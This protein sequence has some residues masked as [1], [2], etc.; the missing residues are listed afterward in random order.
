MNSLT[1]KSA[2]LIPVYSTLIISET[3]EN[4]LTKSTYPSIFQVTISSTVTHDL[5]ES[6]FM[7]FYLTVLKNV[8]GVIRINGRAVK[9]V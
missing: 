2:K 4:K 5:G 9:V 6:I 8:G 7:S 3:T 1:S